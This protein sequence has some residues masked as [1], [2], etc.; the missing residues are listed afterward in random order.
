MHPPPPP[1]PS[2]PNRPLPLQTRHRHRS[3]HRRLGPPCTAAETTATTIK[4]FHNYGATPS[5]APSRW[6][7]RTSQN[8]WSTTGT[9]TASSRTIPGTASMCTGRGAVH[10]PSNQSFGC[11]AKALETERGYLPKATWEYLVWVAGWIGGCCGQTTREINNSTGIT[12]CV[13]ALT[14]LKFNGYT[15][16]IVIH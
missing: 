9:F 1:S 10:G 15:S 13:P 12:C 5:P 2:V 16:Q 8:S 4:I 3:L 6:A 7:T 11:Y 14:T